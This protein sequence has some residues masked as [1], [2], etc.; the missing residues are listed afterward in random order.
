[1]MKKKNVLIVLFL[2][3]LLGAGLRIYNLDAESLW[4]DEP[5]SIIDAKQESINGVIESVN[6]NEAHSPPLYYILLHYWVKYVG[7]SVFVL[8]LFS[9][10]FGILSILLVFLVGKEVFGDEAGLIGALVFCL[11]VV[12]ILYSQE[13]RSYAFFSFLVLAS[14]YF[15]IRILKNDKISE[16]VFYFLSTLAMVY[17]LP[18]GFVV[19]FFQNL[20]VF[21]FYEKHLKI[22]KRWIFGQIGVVLLFLPEFSNFLRMAKENFGLLSVLAVE[23]YGVPAVLGNWLVV[24]LVG[25]VFLTAFVFAVFY[26]RKEIKLV[27]GRFE[28]EKYSYL[29]LL[30]LVLLWVGYFYLTPVLMSPFGLTRYTLFAM[31]FLYLMIGAGV[32]KIKGLLKVIVVFG[33]VLLLAYPLSIYYPQTTKEDWRGAVQYIEENLKEGDLVVLCSSAGYAFKYYYNRANELINSKSYEGDVLE[34]IKGRDYWV[35][36]SPFHAKGKVCEE[37]LSRGEPL[38]S[39]S[40]YGVEVGYFAG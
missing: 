15:F 13:I 21:F 4:T 35:V 36:Y 34:K 12:E 2:I 39:E 22:I 33:M 17:V 23:K 7:E 20:F 24:F 8:R 31:P 37:L 3:I 30:F 18:F 5:F 32:S 38:V 14:V 26:F 28:F 10:I 16:H 11:S 29:F 25:C 40:F 6:V 9:A 1:M 19:V 27:V